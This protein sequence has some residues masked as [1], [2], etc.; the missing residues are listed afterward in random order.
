[1]Q[2]RKVC[3]HPELFEVRGAVTP[4]VMAA[5]DFHVPACLFDISPQPGEAD[6][7]AVLEW[8]GLLKPV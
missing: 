3:N 4:F 2:L 1:M 8:K 7:F 6:A 5:L